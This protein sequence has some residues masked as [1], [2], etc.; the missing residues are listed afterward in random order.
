MNRPGRLALLCTTLAV[1]VAGSIVALVPATTAGAAPDQRP[2]RATYHNPLAPKVG[3]GTTVDSCADPTVLRG[4]RGRHAPWFMW[5]TSDPFNDEDV[6]Q[7]GAPTFHQLPAMRSRD[8]V[9]WRYV[10]DALPTPPDWAADGAHIWAPDVVYSRATDRYYLSFVVTDVDD[11]VRGPNACPSGDDS[12]IGVAVSDRPTGPWQV[13]DTPLVAP[14]PDPAGSCAFFWTFDPDVLGNSVGR[15]SVLYYGSYYGGVQARRVQ[16]TADGATTTGRATQVTRG[17]IHG[18]AA[19]A[20]TRLRSE[21][22]PTASAPQQITIGNRY[23]GT[24]VVR[25][26]GFY[27]LFASATNC[28]NGPLTSYGVF[29]GRSRS[30]MGPFVDKEG[31]SLLAGRVGGSP[32]LLPN[33][34]R[35]LGVGHNTVFTDAAGRW[36]TIYHAVDRHD[37]YF[38]FDP[39]FTKRPALLD[40]LDWVDGWP[41]VRAGRWASDQRMPAPAT[42]PR[43]PSAYRPHPPAPLR[44][45][46]YLPAY[47]DTFAGRQLSPA[48]HWTREPASGYAVENGALRFDTQAGDL[49]VDTNTAS[50][51][52]RRAPRGDYVVQTRVRL[53]LPPEG[54]CFN[55]VQAGMVLRAAGAQGDDRFVKLAHVSIWETRQTEWAKEVPTAPAEYPRYGNG[56]VG[57]PGDV[58]WLRIAVDQRRGEDRFTAYTSD[59][60]RFWVKGGTWTHDLGRA[61]RIGL[62]SMGGTGFTAHF[63]DVRTW[64]TR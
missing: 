18:R 58:T 33:G 1:A 7:S 42:S 34:N 6:D 10:G 27:W 25:R 60:G 53:N 37:P 48:W 62:I 8:L 21:Q 31:R 26:N 44:L 52:H 22:A 36:W 16:F 46:R 9:H 54:C 32:V 49:F 51:L 24:N 2:R 12:A 55:Y 45:G 43:R 13:S 40:P 39:G 3:D 38:A 59:N 23:E 14:R 20:A 17:S 5:C 15:S 63:L 19:A 29:A 41:Q 30:P 4:Q 57:P 28:C 50:V 56:V 64:R 47:S 61:P 11:S 35:W